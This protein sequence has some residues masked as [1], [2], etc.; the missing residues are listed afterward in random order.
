MIQI[1]AAHLSPEPTART[2]GMAMMEIVLLPLHPCQRGQQRDY[3]SF[4]SN[5]SW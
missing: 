2:A 3:K 4:D 5:S 1:L